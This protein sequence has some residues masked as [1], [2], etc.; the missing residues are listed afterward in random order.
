MPKVPSKRRARQ[1]TSHHLGNEEKHQNESEGQSRGNTRANLSTGI[2][3]CRHSWKASLGQKTSIGDYITCT[4][5]HL[6]PAKIAPVKAQALT[7]VKEENFKHI[8][9]GLDVNQP[10][11]PHCLGSIFVTPPKILKQQLT[12][13]CTSPASS[14]MGHDNKHGW[15]EEHGKFVAV[16]TGSLSSVLLVSDSLV[17]GHARYHRV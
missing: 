13:Y 16:A 15:Y 7:K 9:S 17:N 4:E 6:T 8:T 2:S 11:L 10:T 14:P 5:T 1:S 12:G 3:Y